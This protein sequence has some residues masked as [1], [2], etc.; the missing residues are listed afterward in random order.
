VVY[1][2]WVESEELRDV[3]AAVL[4]VERPEMEFYNANDKYN[5]NSVP[6]QERSLGAV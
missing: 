4:G 1:E 3:A 5:A 2:Q 6:P